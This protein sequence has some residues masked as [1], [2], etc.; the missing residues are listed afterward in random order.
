MTS[1]AVSPVRRIAGVLEDVF[2]LT[3][4]VVSVPVAILV[5][6][7]PFVLLLRLVQAIAGRP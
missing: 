3:A 2:W 1:P 5:L 6:G 7:A 4:I